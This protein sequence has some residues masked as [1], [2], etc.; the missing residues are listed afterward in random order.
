MIRVHSLL[1]QSPHHYQ[2]QIPHRRPA[3]QPNGYYVVLFLALGVAPAPDKAG[4]ARTPGTLT[5]I[6]SGKGDVVEK[7]AKGAAHYQGRRRTVMHEAKGRR[8]AKGVRA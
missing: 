2:T 1:L 5:L 7:G 3:Q 4:A 8:A 6:E